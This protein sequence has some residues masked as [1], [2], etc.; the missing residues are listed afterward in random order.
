MLPDSTISI[1]QSSETAALAGALIIAAAFPQVLDFAA[2]VVAGPRGSIERPTPAS[3][4]RGRGRPQRAR[5]SNGHDRRESPDQIDARLL[6]AM[7]ANPGAQI[8]TLAEA[9]GKSKTTTVTSLNRLRDAGLAD[10]V[11][12]VWQLTEPDPPPP[13]DPP[14]RWTAPLS[15]TARRRNVETEERAQA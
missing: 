10:S 2:R 15:G 4:K 14:P 12:R 3:P 8:A 13:R 6:E 11:D 1:L 5:R 7:K 9:I